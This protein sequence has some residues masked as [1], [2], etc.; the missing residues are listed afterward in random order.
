MPLKSTKYSVYL[1]NYHIISILKHRKHLL[2]EKIAEKLKEIFHEIA[3]NYGME[4]IAKEV[5]LDHIHIFVS[6]LLKYAQYHIVKYFKGI[7]SKLLEKYFPDSGFKV[8]ET[9]TRAYFVSTEGNVSSEI[10][11]LKD[12]M[13]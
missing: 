2:T 12:T 5:M 8:S 4:I 7:S 3:Y 9:C 6:A 11:K 10:I 1:C 13:G